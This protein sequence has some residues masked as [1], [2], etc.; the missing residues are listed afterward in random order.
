MFTIVRTLW[1]GVLATAFGAFGPRSALAETPGEIPKPWTYEGSMKLQQ[2]QQEQAPSQQPWPQPQ[3]SPGGTNRGS[4]GDGAAAAAAEAARR[5]WLGR[6]ALPPDRNPLLGSK[7]TRPA[8]TQANSADPFGQLLALA[9]GGLCELLFGGGVFEF[10]PDALVGS[11]A[12]TGETELDRVDY[13]GDERHV[14]VV[15][16]TTIRL[17]EFDIESPSR[18][19]WSSQN[20]V[21]VRAGS[22][23]AGAAR[24]QT[25]ALAGNAQPTAAVAAR[26][27]GVLSL[28]VRS[29]SPGSLNV[30][31]RTLWVLRKDAQ[32]ALI[33]GGLQSTP[34]GT[35]LQNWMR[36]C[37][38]RLPAC[39]Q[40]A[41]AL[42]RY[43]IGVA[44]TDAGGHA[45][46]PPLPAARYWVLSDAK[47]D[48]RHMMWNEPVDVRDGPALL[49]LDQHNAKPVDRDR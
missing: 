46:S 24:A 16:R 45:Q 22:A 23:V 49:T 39:Q 8:S 41:L 13:R 36:A 27:G 20:C 5:K 48:R 15:P 18:I 26:P 7:W 12:R 21:L 32:V 38:S 2:Q 9:K 3:A 28:S 11:D 6:P 14:V 34:D 33:E 43:T 10:R 47:V 42:K 37:Q 4:P 44:T 30:A 25:A 31:G 29:A 19:N 17:M 1:V 35:A 40:G